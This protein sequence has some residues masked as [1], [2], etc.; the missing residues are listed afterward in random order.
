MR[1]C[2]RKVRAVIDAVAKGSYLHVVALNVI[3]GRVGDVSHTSIL[4]AVERD[5]LLDLDDASLLDVHGIDLHH[6]FFVLHCNVVV[7]VS[8]VASV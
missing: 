8:V 3:D 6:L 2:V 1:V 4:A 5:Q 7:E